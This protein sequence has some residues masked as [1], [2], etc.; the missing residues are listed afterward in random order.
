MI[1]GVAIKIYDKWHIL[2]YI[3]VGMVDLSTNFDDL[4]AFSQFAALQGLLEEKNIDMMKIY[5]NEGN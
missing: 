5:F 4:P 3:F 1:G 2:V